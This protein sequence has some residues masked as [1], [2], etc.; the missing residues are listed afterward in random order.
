[1]Q[2]R[3]FLH[4]D[5]L[6]RAVRLAGSTP[7]IG[8]E[9][10]Q[11]AAARETTVGEIADRLKH[12]FQEIDPKKDIRI[13]YMEPRLGDVKRNFSDTSKA[14]ARL[15]WQPEVQLDHGLRATLDWFVHL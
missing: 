6:I 11:I 10:F 4:I 12:L 7:D 13:S 2:T 8:G 15:G 5:D 14:K 9:T 3:D 1:M